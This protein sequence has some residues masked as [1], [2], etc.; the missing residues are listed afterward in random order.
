M[1]MLAPGGFEVMNNLPSG[2]GDWDAKSWG[3]RNAQ[4]RRI[5]DALAMALA[6]M[7]IL[8]SEIVV[9][10]ICEEHYSQEKSI[11]MGLLGKM[12]VEPAD[13]TIPVLQ[14]RNNK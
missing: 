5:L 8:R 10:K 9:G 12:R 13:I 11:E 14:Y 1:E 6:P 3:N 4:Q 2:A 7:F